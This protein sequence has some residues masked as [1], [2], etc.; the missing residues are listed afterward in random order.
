MSDRGKCFSKLPVGRLKKQNSVWG[1][2]GIIRYTNGAVYKGFTRDKQFNGK[3]R[4]VHQ[5]GDI[6]H[7]EWLNGKAH[8]QGVFIQYGN[9]SMYDGEWH[10]DEMHGFGT[11]IWD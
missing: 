11:E 3:G 7:G 4:L 8:G 2:I 10:Q 9:N 1:G 5:N 6:Y